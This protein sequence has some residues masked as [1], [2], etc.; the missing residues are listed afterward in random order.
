MNSVKCPECGLVNFASASECKRCHL[1]FHQSDPVPITSSADAG[2]ASPVPNQTSLAASSPAV[3]QPFSAAHREVTSAVS[4]EDPNAKPKRFSVP[5]F[6]FLI[7]LLLNFAVLVYQFAHFLTLPKSGMWKY[8]TDPNQMLYMPGFAATMYGSWALNT[9]TILASLLLLIPFFLKSRS[10]LK[11]VRVYLVFILIYSIVEVTTGLSFRYAL[12]QR[13]PE[14]DP[15]IGPMLD[16]M[17]WVSILKI[18][19]FMVAFI[20]LRYFE[21]SERVKK[22]FIK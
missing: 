2:A 4:S 5:M 19:G 7:Y 10:F 14:N 13:L 11:L 17:Y 18:A 9:L 3:A 1:K 22:T 16:N 15:V 8:V 20:W 6:V 12:T 21:T